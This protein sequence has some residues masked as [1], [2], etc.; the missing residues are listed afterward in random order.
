MVRWTATQPKPPEMLTRDRLIVSYQINPIL[1]R[2][3]RTTGLLTLF[4]VG[5]SMVWLCF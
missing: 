1:E 2:L 3:T 5:D 4:M